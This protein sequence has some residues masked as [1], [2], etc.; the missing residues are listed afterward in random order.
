MIN[1]FSRH[2][3]EGPGAGYGHIW[4]TTDGGATWTDVSG[5]PAAAGSF[6]DVPANAALITRSGTLVV[7]TD[8]GV[9]TG[10]STGHWAHLGTG[11]P[12]SPAVYLSP[13]PDGG[14]VYVA[15]HG[16][17]IWKTRTP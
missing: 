3:N 7:A 11:L 13:S 14:R 5:D 17:G 15:T 2:W 8:L 12:T 4:K 16:R 9:S 1:G 10:T 6:P